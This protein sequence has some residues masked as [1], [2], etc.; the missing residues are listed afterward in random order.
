MQTLRPSSKCLPRLWRK[1]E[2]ENKKRHAES[3]VEEL[4]NKVRCWRTHRLKFAASMNMQ[5][6]KRAADAAK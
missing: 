1:N 2:S 4:E 3:L 5:E 6:A